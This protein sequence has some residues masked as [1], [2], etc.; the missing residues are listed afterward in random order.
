MKSTDSYGLQG[1]HKNFIIVDDLIY[2]PFKAW[3]KSLFTKYPVPIGLTHY[4]YI[5][6]KKKGL[7]TL[8]KEYAEQTQKQIKDRVENGPNIKV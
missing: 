1:K 4:Y 8:V 3:W 6:G 5:R 2:S 7:Y